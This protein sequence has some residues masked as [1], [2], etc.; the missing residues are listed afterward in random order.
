MILNLKTLRKQLIVWRFPMMS[1]LFK[2]VSFVIPPVGLLATLFLV[3]KEDFE[4][5]YDF[6]SLFFAGLTAY[7][8]I[9]VL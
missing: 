7:F 1:F 8:F 9:L 2:I 3:G 5:A 6:A 4:N